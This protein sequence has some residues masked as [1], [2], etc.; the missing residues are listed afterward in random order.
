MKE[1]ITNILIVTPILFILYHLYF[2]SKYSLY[3]TNKKLREKVIGTENEL[4]I[5]DADNTMMGIIVTY[6]Y[7]LQRSVLFTIIGN[8]LFYLLI[9]GKVVT[10]ADYS[11][12]CSII[13]VILSIVGII[14]HRYIDNVVSE[15]TGMDD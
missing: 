11:M 5:Q 15:Y 6:W 12:I 1:C 4:E 13:G 3:F 9:I 8:I 10:R 2:V 14:F 7:G